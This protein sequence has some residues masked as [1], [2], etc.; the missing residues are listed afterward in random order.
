MLFSHGNDAKFICLN[1]VDVPGNSLLRLMFVFG[2]SG[3]HFDPQL[4]AKIEGCNRRIAPRNL[5]NLP[6]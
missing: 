1:S 2:F 5:A 6:A 4:G 3:V